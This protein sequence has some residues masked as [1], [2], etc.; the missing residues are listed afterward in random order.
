MKQVHAESVRAKLFHREAGFTS[1]SFVRNEGV[2]WDDE[3]SVGARGSCGEGFVRSRFARINRFMRP[4]PRA[5]SR[6]GGNMKALSMPRARVL[7]PRFR[8]EICAMHVHM[9]R[10]RFRK[11][12]TKQVLHAGLYKATLHEAAVYEAGSCSSRKLV[13]IGDT[14]FTIGPSVSIRRFSCLRR[15]RSRRSF[16][17]CRFLRSSFVQCGFVYEAGSYSPWDHEVSLQQK[18]Y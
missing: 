8:E 11:V 13:P 3:G 14:D 12:C 5:K 2:L 4:T 9:V 15:L 1:G 7:R 16:V 6:L 17:P 18:S 10:L